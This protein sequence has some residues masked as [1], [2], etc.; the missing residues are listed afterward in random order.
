MFATNCHL[1]YPRCKAK[2]HWQSM[3]THFQNWAVTMSLCLL[4]IK[5]AITLVMQSSNQKRGQRVAGGELRH[6]AGLPRI[7]LALVALILVKFIQL[8]KWF[9]L[10]S[11]L[12]F[13]NQY[14]HVTAQYFPI[15]FHQSTFPV[16]QQKESGENTLTHSGMLVIVPLI[17]SH[18]NFINCHQQFFS[19]VVWLLCWLNQSGVIWW[20]TDILVLWGCR[21]LHSVV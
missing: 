9:V 1:D 17:L 21:M 18:F 2:Y 16:K 6:L 4:P 7:I 19:H 20:G 13:L 12:L 11:I 3:D 8:A 5:A 15:I 14:S 10:C